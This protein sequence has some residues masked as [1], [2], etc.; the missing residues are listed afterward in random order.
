[1]G[2]CVCKCIGKKG[3]EEGTVIQS[4]RQKGLYPSLILERQ[5]E[6][7]MDGWMDGYRYTHRY[8]YTWT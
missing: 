7:W 4:S 1:M 5:I 8:I 6:M 3:F 2:T